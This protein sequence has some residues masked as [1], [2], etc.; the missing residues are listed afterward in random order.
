MTAGKK[1]DELRHCHA[2]GVTA[3]MER[4]LEQ[5]HPTG[6]A[7]LQILNCCTACCPQPLFIADECYMELMMVVEPVSPQLLLQYEIMEKNDC[8]RIL[9][10]TGEALISEDDLQCESITV[11]ILSSILTQLLYEI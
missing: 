9:R 5:R 2:A 1:P 6:I 10:L 3:G 11:Y 4:L 7:C 8:L